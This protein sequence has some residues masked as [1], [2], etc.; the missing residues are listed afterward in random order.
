ME[1]DVDTV[2]GRTLNSELVGTVGML[3]VMNFGVVEHCASGTDFLV[4]IK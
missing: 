3:C 1:V 4:G 2:E